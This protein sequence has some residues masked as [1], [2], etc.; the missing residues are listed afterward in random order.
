MMDSGFRP[1]YRLTKRILV[2]LFVTKLLGRT[3][4]FN[5]IVLNKL[6]FYMAVSSILSIVKQRYQNFAG[7]ECFTVNAASPREENSNFSI[8]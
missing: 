4:I 5:K 8:S 2:I 7:G 3:N 1:K 6:I